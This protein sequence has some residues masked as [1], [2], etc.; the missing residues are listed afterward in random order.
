MCWGRSSPRLVI[1]RR[2]RDAAGSS[3]YG[4]AVR[5]RSFFGS[6]PS[7]VVLA[8]FQ[9]RDGSH[10]LEASSCV[11]RAGLGVEPVDMPKQTL[12]LPNLL[13]AD[14]VP[15]LEEREMG[16]ALLLATM[17]LQTRSHA[18]LGGHADVDHVIIHFPS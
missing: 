12:E 6:S 9:L 16:P 15:H 1:S 7:G 18:A 2:R 4:S 8:E 11:Q 10:R 17:T 3:N 5:G 13:V 14:V